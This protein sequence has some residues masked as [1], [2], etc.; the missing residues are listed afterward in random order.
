MNKP[1]KLILD[2]STWRCGE[3]GEH[4]L[5]EGLTQLCNDDGFMCCL[6]QWSIQQGASKEEMIGKGEPNEINT[7][8]PLFAEKI[9]YNSEA[10]EDEIKTTE[11]AY[12]AIGINDDEKTTPEQKI[13]LLTQLLA[14]QGIALEVINKPQ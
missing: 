8:I 4:S 6:G 10:W 13:D 5:G 7:L 9:K 2:Y 1:E 14:N 3:D 12:D 11:L